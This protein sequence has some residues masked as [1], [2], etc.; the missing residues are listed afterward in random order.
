MKR[1]NYVK[2]LGLALAIILFGVL[3]WR[4]MYL[5]PSNT[6][7][8]TSIINAVSNHY[9]LPDEEPTIATVEDKDKVQSEFLR[10]AANGDRILIYQKAKKVILYRPSIDRIVEVGPVSI[11]SPLDTSTQ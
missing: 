5:E 8:K 1:S 9:L 10:S 4:L 7:T 11:A 2:L 6:Q 3:V